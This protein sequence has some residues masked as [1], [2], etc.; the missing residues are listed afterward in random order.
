VNAIMAENEKICLEHGIRFDYDIQI[1][2]PLK[3]NPVV[4]CSLFSNLLR[5]AITATRE[6]EDASQ[7][8]V[9]VKSAVKGDYVH[10]KVENSYADKPRRTKKN[11]RGYGLSILKTIA[12]RYSG[13]MEQSADGEKYS[14]HIVVENIEK[15]E[16]NPSLL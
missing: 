4:I 5:N 16:M 6:M 13:R 7:A 8:Y 15:N 3:L 9:F 1:L 12:D 14:V 10:I 11:R 2:Q